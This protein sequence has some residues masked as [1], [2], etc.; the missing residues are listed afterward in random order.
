MDNSQ[1]VNKEMLVTPTK[2]VVT[3]TEDF[4]SPLFGVQPSGADNSCEHKLKIIKLHEITNIC[5]RLNL[6]CSK[7]KR[8]F[9]GVVYQYVD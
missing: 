6:K 2:E 1:S 4:T 9:Q 8:K 7:C 5:L 3:P